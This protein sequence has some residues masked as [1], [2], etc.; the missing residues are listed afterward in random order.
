MKISK[1]WAPSQRF[2]LRSHSKSLNF[3]SDRDNVYTIR[4]K[5]LNK[6]KKNIQK[7]LNHTYP[8]FHIVF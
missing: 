4:E 2:F 8:D 6:A 7:N 1:F 5:K 3:T